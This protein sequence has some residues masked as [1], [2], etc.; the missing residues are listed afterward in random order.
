MKQIIPLWTWTLQT[1]ALYKCTTEFLYA[2]NPQKHLHKNLYNL[3]PSPK[4]SKK[5]SMKYKEIHNRP[6]IKKML[7]NYYN[8]MYKI[9]PEGINQI[10]KDR[11]NIFYIMAERYLQDAWR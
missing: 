6:E 3:V 2:F 11:N 10:V 1:L 4:G 7:H 5:L 9:N 8:N